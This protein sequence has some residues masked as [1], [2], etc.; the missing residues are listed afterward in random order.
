MKK[1]VFVRM[2]VF[3][4]GGMLKRSSRFVCVG[5]ANFDR[6]KFVVVLLRDCMCKHEEVVRFFSRNGNSKNFD[7][8][9]SE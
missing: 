5:S 1:R 9:K 6:I 4:F 8:E 2:D 3:F 7:A